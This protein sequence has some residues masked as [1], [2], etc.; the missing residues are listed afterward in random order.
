MLLRNFIDHNPVPSSSVW[1]KKSVCIV[2]DSLDNNCEET[3]VIDK[4]LQENF[5]YK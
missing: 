1:T 2:F 4:F 5:T 3:N